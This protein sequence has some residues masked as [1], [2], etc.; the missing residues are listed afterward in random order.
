MKKK[1][2][3]AP[4]CVAVNATVCQMLAS[5]ITGSAPDSDDSEFG[6]PHNDAENGEIFGKINGNKHK[7]CK[8]L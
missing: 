2:Y 1:K 3:I 5:S 4:V 8:T 7:N 6:A